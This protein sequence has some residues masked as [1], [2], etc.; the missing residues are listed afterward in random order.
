MAQPP[1]PWYINHW[2]IFVGS[3]TSQVVMGLSA[4]TAFLVLSWQGDGIWFRSLLLTIALQS[5]LWEVGL[6][7]IPPIF[8]LLT[9]RS[10]LLDL[11]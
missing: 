3:V 8:R 2:R 4:P 6:A 11:T 1:F 9:S 5:I 7:C 10:L